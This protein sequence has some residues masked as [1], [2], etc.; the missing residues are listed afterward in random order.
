M[1]IG[2][3]IRNRLPRIDFWRIRSLCG[4]RSR[5]GGF[6]RS[7]ADAPRH[8]LGSL[9]RGAMRGPDSTR[10]GARLA[11]ALR[12]QEISSLERRVVVGDQ[13]E[14]ARL[15]ENLL[16]AP[17]PAARAI[18]C[19]V[20]A[21]SPS[22]GG[23]AALRAVLLDTSPIPRRALCRAL[24]KLVAAPRLSEE[25]RRSLDALLAHAAETYPDHRLPALPGAILTMARVPGPKVRAILTDTD[26]PIHMTLRAALR[27]ARFEGSRAAAVAA[28][29]FDPLA[30]AALDRLTQPDSATEHDGALRA[31]ALLINPARRRRLARATPGV[32]PTRE[33]GESLSEEARLG[34]V[35]WTI[36]T[37]MRPAERR[38]RLGA[39]AA[40]PCL[41]VSVAAERALA[42]QEAAAGRERRPAPTIGARSSDQRVGRLVRV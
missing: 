12:W 8:A 18:A 38:D 37:P 32:L 13:F 5:A 41:R 22:P 6:T 26:Q 7:I 3:A 21:F 17:D 14:C 15:V 28:L 1:R 35:K 9:I 42:R 11:A 19:E 36:A 20:A 25:T 2:I 29:A 39:L 30:S 34:L 16:Q 4:A 31:W 24:G 40:D 33:L 23:V 27:R 10:S